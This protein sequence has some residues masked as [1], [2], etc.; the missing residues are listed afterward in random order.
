MLSEGQRELLNFCIL[1]KFYWNF[2]PFNVQGDS[3]N[4]HTWNKFQPLA[5][6]WCATHGENILPTIAIF[7]QFLVYL[8]ITQAKQ[9]INLLLLD[10]F[11]PVIEDELS[12]TV[13]SLVTV[14]EPVTS[15]RG[16]VTLPM[17]NSIMQKVVREAKYGVSVF[18]RFR[19]FQGHLNFF[20]LDR[21]FF[22]SKIERILP[23]VPTRK[24]LTHICPKL[25][26]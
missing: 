15:A 8:S 3:R 25:N 7:S 13:W 17:K 26:D 11:Y 22:S 14:R 23:Y 16:Y 19:N 4:L 1:I 10:N 24:V 20:K 21:I 6:E 5:L 12:Y 18:S 9:A 2:V